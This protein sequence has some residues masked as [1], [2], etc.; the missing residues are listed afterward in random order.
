MLIAPLFDSV[1][2]DDRGSYTPAFLILGGSG[3]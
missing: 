2:F 3:L 1:M